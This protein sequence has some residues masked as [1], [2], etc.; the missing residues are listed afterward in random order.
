[1]GTRDLCIMGGG[2]G[3]G[4]LVRHKVTLKLLWLV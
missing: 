1:M 2:G 4:L 3:L